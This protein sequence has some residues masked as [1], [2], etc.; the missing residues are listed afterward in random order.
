MA[1]SGKQPSFVVSRVP[2]TISMTPLARCP[3][4][5]NHPPSQDRA[6]PF[7]QVD[8]SKP[9]TTLEGCDLQTGIRQNGMV[10]LKKYNGKEKQRKSIRLHTHTP[11][12]TS[13]LP[14]PLVCAKPLYLVGTDTKL[15]AKR[16]REEGLDFGGV[17]FAPPPP[18][19]GSKPLLPFSFPPKLRPF[20]W[21]ALRHV[22]CPNVDP[23]LS[24]LR[25]CPIRCQFFFRK[26]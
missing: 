19:L 6:T 8:F 7:D 5:P 11:P 9:L 16:K 23:L 26:R 13:S 2:D 22:R 14:P 10:I 25:L 12:P 21:V 17:G 4:F 15:V 18:F 3:P 24:P 1:L 20:S